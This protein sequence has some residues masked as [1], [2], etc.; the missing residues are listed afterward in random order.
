MIAADLRRF[1]ETSVGIVDWVTVIGVPI[2]LVQLR[3]SRVQARGSFE[4]QFV[5][6]YWSIE[7]DRLADRTGD[8]EAVHRRRYFRLTEDQFELM[9]LG[10]ISW[11]TWEIW[12][13]GIAAGAA[14]F[15]AAAHGPHKWLEACTSMSA[16]F[17]HECEALTTPDGAVRRRSKADPGLWWQRARRAW[18]R[19]RSG[20]QEL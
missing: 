18:W 6:R 8:S 20:A 12:H 16:H 11:S 9:R 7:D 2:A 13:D 19:I 15:D 10:Q 3:A 4:Q 14:D 1:E 17:G 5:D